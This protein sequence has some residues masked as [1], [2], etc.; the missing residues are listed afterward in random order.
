MEIGVLASVGTGRARMSPMRQSAG[1]ARERTRASLSSGEIR[2]LR[3]TASSA[4]RQWVAR[5]IPASCR[6]PRLGR[7]VARCIGSWNSEPVAG[8]LGFR[9]LVCIPHD[10]FSH[11]FGPL[12]EAGRGK[13]ELE[14]PGAIDGHGHCHF[15]GCC[16]RGMVFVVLVGVVGSHW[17][18]GEA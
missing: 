17:P 7:S 18:V 8:N 15:R 3:R 5:R 11:T 12:G 6:D 2:L 1:S 16:C 10:C 14:S 9:E 4:A 13:A